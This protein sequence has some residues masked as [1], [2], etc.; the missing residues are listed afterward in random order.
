[1]ARCRRFY[2][3]GADALRRS[4]K[5]FDG[6]NADLTAAVDWM[7][8]RA[9]AAWRAVW[10]LAVCSHELRP[11]E[12]PPPFY[13]TFQAGPQLNPDEHQRPLP[14]Q[15]LVLQ[16]KSTAKFDKAS[17]DDLW[18]RPKETLGEEL[19]Q[20][21]EVSVT[22]VRLSPRGSHAM[23]RQPWWAWWESS[24][25]TPGSRGGPSL[26]CRGCRAIGA[27]RSPRPSSTPRAPMMWCSGSK[28]MWTPS[29][30]APRRRF[31]AAVVRLGKGI[32]G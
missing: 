6:S 14:T 1:M 22:P 3:S 29:R 11:C 24:E 26:R 5:G 2:R 17:F 21:N 28:A 12:T 18:Q 15:F 19:V 23:P 16:L 32:F 27:P 30:I 10:R 31:R 9:A 8:G 20:S 25:L 7:E 13:V 4:S